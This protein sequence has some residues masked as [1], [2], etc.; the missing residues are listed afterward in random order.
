LSLRAFVTKKKC[1]QDTKALRNT[2]K[3]K[4]LSIVKILG[5]P[6][7]LRALVA[8]KKYHPDTKRKETPGKNKSR[9]ESCK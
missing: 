3:N 6:L 1:H 9:I 7:C 8:K 5:E 4:H 2:K